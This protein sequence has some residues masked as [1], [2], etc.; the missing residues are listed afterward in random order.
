MSNARAVLDSKDRRIKSGRRFRINGVLDMDIFSSHLL[1][2]CK[3]L[4][5][6]YHKKNHFLFDG[7]LGRSGRV[8]AID[9]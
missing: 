3:Q 4:R 8:S 1:K 2:K 6:E 7:D 9:G 5:E